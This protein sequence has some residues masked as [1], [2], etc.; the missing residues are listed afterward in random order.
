MEFPHLFD[1]FSL[2][3]LVLR[4][5]V[6]MA[7]MTRE[8]SPGGVPGP[9]VAA[10]YGR[11]SAGGVGLILTEGAAPCPEGSFG[12]DVPRLY[13]DRALNGWRKVVDAVHAHGA[14]IFAQLWHVGAFTPAMIGMTDS[15]GGDTRRVSP[16]GLAAPGH[17]FGEP[18]SVADIDDAIAAFGRSAAAAKR[19]GFDGVEIHAAHGY[20][21]DQF[22]WHGT[23]LRA[24]SYGGDL[25]ART[26]FACEVIGEIKRLAGSRFPVSVRISQW[27]Q[28]DYGAC[29][30][31]SPDALAD[32]LVPLV[33]AGAD[34][35]HASTRRFWEPAFEQSE[36]S[37]AAWVKKVCDA[38]VIAVGSVTLANDFKSRRGKQ[39]AALSLRQLN[40]IDRCLARGDFDLIAIGRAILSNPDWAN[41]VREGRLAELRPFSRAVLERLD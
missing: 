14:G 1:P 22:F 29:I 18:M 6:V 38:P 28:L 25:R 37:F 24:D 17:R 12:I 40:A 39:A 32:W 34:L 21:P 27:K 2:G 20:L 31:D 33:D 23:N 9:D 3:G 13:G 30:V 36:L 15:L 19:V 4:N 35:I 5:R 16:S 10:Y 26:R 8:M 11:R 41:L 7:P